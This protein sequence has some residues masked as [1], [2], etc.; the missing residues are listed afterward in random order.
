MTHPAGF[1]NSAQRVIRS[2]RALH[3]PEVARLL[4]FAIAALKDLSNETA[5]VSSTGGEEVRRDRAEPTR[6]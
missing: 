6:F 4:G 3:Q 5:G 1:G 2:A